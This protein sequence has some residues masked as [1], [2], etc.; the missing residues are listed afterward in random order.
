MIQPVPYFDLPGIVYRLD[1]RTRARH[2]EFANFVIAPEATESRSSLTALLSAIIPIAPNAHTWICEDRWRLLGLAQCLARPGA[3]AWDLAYLAAMVAPGGQPAVTPE[4]DVLMELVQYALNAALQRGVQR[5]FARVEDDRPELEIFGK[6]GFQRYA[7]EL[8]YCLPSA[9]H[10]LEHLAQ[11]RLP[12]PLGQY[13]RDDEEAGPLPGAQDAPFDRDAPSLQQTQQAEDERNAAQ[14]GA[15]AADVS[16]AASAPAVLARIDAIDH[17]DELPGGVRG[18]LPEVPLRRWR[19]HDAWGLLRLYD[20]CT[21]RRVQLA[22]SV[23]NDEFV[24][25]RAGGG[26][27]WRLPLLE[28]SDAAFVNDHGV[29][30]GGWLRLRFGRGSLPHQLWCMAHPDEPETALAL[31][32]FGLRVLAREAP[33]PVVCQVREYEGPIIDALRAAGFE[34]V[35]SHALLVRHLTLRALRNREVPALEPRVVY[36]IKGLGTAPTRLSKGEKTHYATG[37]H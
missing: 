28:P 33:L 13:G 8:T 30:L 20:A 1:R 37:D 35:G 2:G 7:R 18:I 10:G 22:E 5:F 34:H 6:Q 26:R 11:V 25:T 12:L 29:R 3:D 31:V 24:H 4:Y 19:R 15:P 16:H 32:R 27:T 21:P 36:G 14:A 17:D 9:A 23:T